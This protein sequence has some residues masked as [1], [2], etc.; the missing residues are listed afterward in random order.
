[1]FAGREQP[2]QEPNNRRKIHRSLATHQMGCRT[3]TLPIRRIGISQVFHRED[4][5]DAKN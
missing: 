5:K 4:A 1:M 2:C 3:M